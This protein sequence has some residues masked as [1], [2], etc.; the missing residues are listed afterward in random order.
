MLV[1]SRKRGERIVIGS[2]VV[3]TVVDVHGDRVKLAFD[4]PM[5]IPIFREEVYRQIQCEEQ[6]LAQHQPPNQSPYYAAFA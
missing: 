6:E 1:L 3:L 4:A 2:N 5:N